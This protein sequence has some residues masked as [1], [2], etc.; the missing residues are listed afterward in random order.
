ML[1]GK[2]CAADI[3]SS[4]ALELYCY[5]QGVKPA[6]ASDFTPYS[7]SWAQLI[8]TATQMLNRYCDATPRETGSC[9]IGPHVSGSLSTVVAH[10]S[11][12]V[13]K[14]DRCCSCRN[15][16]KFILKMVTNADE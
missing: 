6:A 4:P 11:L 7:G 8:Q 14:N 16:V 3:L 5:L 2:T 9:I 13:I 1:R 12:T 10:Y 15:M